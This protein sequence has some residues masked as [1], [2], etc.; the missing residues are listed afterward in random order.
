MDNDRAFLGEF[1]K[2]KIETLDLPKDVVCMFNE[3]EPI[4]MYYQELLNSHFFTSIEMLMNWIMVYRYSPSF[5]DQL[6]VGLKNTLD[7][8]YDIYKS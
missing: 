4:Y 1:M 6:L 5:S 2:R 7:N 8:G 3:F